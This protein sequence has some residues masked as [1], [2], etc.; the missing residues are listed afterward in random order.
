MQGRICQA[1]NDDNQLAKGVIAGGLLLYQNLYSVREKN[2]TAA[3]RRGGPTLNP[4]KIKK[5]PKIGGFSH[6]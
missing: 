6:P 4:Q 3:R 2:L 5:P 1:K